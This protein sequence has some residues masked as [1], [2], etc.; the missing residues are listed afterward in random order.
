[1]TLNLPKD[2]DVMV[3][4]RDYDFF[5]PKDIE[6]KEVVVSGKAYVTQVSVEEQ[7]HLAEDNG[8]TE[9]E[10]AQITQPKR[11]LSFLADGVQIKK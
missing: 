1:M 3:K 4:F 9:K 2:E 6:E 5:V 10:I 11:T 7:Q 8:K